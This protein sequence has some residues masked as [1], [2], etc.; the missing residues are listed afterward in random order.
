MPKHRVE[1]LIADNRIWFGKDGNNV[2]RIKTFLSEVADSGIVPL[3]IWKYGDV[4]HN[5]EARQELKKLFDDAGY[6]DGPKPVRLLSRILKLATSKDSNDII[7]DFFSG[8]A[9]TAHA[10][11]QQNAEDGG[12]RKFIMVQ[13]PELC[14]EKSEAYRTGYTNICEIGKERLRRAGQ[15]ITAEQD[16]QIGIG[17]AD[18]TPL[19]IGFRV[20]KLDSSNLKLW[21][22]SPIAGE[23]ALLEL[24]RRILGMLDIVKTDRSNMDVVYEV[25]LKL[26]QE[27]TKPIIPIDLGDG[28]TVYGV[29]TG[30][31]AEVKF[32]ICLAHGITPK[33]AE[34]MAEYAPGRIVFADACFDNSEQKTNV[35][36]TLR[37]KGIAIKAL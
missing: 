11:M 4:G 26:G 6:F 5:Q 3:T 2:P 15:K 27:L 20:F 16:G 32:I 30:D 7:L 22:D 36:L 25:M 9:T 23:N 10:V 37:D 35:K 8:S 34:A 19:D 14:D 17:D 1:E 29:G 28:K 18:K 33:D 13:L 31:G 12:N 24:E 21:D